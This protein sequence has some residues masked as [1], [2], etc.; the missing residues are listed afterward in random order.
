MAVQVLNNKLT[1]IKDGGPIIREKVQQKTVE[2]VNIYGERKQ[3]D[4]INVN[5]LAGLLADKLHVSS[6]KKMQAID[7][8]I[9]REISI[10]N[11][12]KNAVTS[13]VI[14]GT[15]NNKLDKLKELRKNGTTNK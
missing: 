10:N 4:N 3:T 15:V 12:D 11:V 1:L 6:P 5:E 2:D 8:D 7:I 14:E 9:K 13:E